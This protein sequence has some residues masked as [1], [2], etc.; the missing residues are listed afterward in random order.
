MLSQEERRLF[1]CKYAE[2]VNC[3]CL[4]SSA[5][6]LF[7]YFLLLNSKVDAKNN[8]TFNY[9]ILSM[10]FNLS[11]DG[12]KTEFQVL[13]KYTKTMKHLIEMYKVGHRIM[14]LFMLDDW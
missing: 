1:Y 6:T 4:E 11:N 3:K 12:N 5:E 2:I 7:F 14:N 8:I 10:M 13:G 9:D